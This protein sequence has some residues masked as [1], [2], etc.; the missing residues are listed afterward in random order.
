MPWLPR[1]AHDKAKV[2]VEEGQVEE[3]KKSKQSQTVHGWVLSLKAD[4]GDVRILPHQATP[5]TTNGF[6]ENP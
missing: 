2:V 6:F 1:L 5:S 3:D 4:E